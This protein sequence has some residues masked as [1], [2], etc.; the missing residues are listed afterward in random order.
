MENRVY[1]FAAGPSM[2]ADEVLIQ[3]KEELF[4]YNETGMSVME[5]SHRSKLYLDIF[6]ETKNDLKK[7]YLIISHLRQLLKEK[8]SAFME[9]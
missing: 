3:L 2:L 4:N 1:N 5:M 6:N 8:Y 9:D 7:L